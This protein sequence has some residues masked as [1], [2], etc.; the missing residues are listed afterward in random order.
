MKLKFL[1]PLSFLCLTAC[2]SA[3]AQSG[4]DLYAENCASCHGSGV[5][6]GSA[7]SLFDDDWSHGADRAQIKRNIVM[8][9]ESAGMPGFEGAMSEPELASL[10]SYV[11]DMPA[12][13]TKTEVLTKGL[14]PGVAAIADLTPAIDEIENMADSLEIEDFLVGLDE[15]WGF[16]FLSQDEVLVTEKRG[17]LWLAT[18]DGQKTEIK[19]TP[20]VNK[21]GQGG[22]LDVALDPDYDENKWVYLTYSHPLSGKSG[23]SMTKLVKGRIVDSNWME[24]QVLFQAKS[25]HYVD[26]KYHYGSRIT[27]DDAGHVYFSIGD[28]G[29][30]DQAQDTNLPNGKIH[31]LKTDGTI[32]EDNPFL[33]SAY[34]SIYSF[35]NR[36]PQGL[37]WHPDTAVLWS[38][39]HGPKGGDELNDIFS[40]KN[41]GWPEISYG[42][43]YNGTELTPYKTKPGMEQPAS[44]WTPSIAVC[45]LD[46]YSGDLFPAWKGR[47]LAGSLAYQSLRL[48]QVNGDQYVDEIEILKDKGRIRDV[49]TGPDGAIYV[50]L[51][52]KIVRLSPAKD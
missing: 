30:K 12:P 52:T 27:F 50:A 32:P 19:N 43:N 26:T 42:I 5:D 39:E 13:Q 36:N 16:T 44:Q 14:K 31:R 46:V 48:V 47:L 33:S 35:G 2:T 20:I 34:P 40:G 38:T 10:M 7:A 23:P 24:E 51:P 3:T 6:G 1:T 9:I 18:S 41:Y 4:A 37:I 25:E 49:T 17:N 11:L 45:G 28:R 29:K 21:G 8:G 15:P 22:L